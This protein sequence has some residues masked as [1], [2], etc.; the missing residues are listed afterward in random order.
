M[1]SFTIA[2]LVGAAGVIVGFILMMAF[3]KKRTKP[4]APSA[5]VKP[6]GK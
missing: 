1:D 3:D 4:Q 5:P 2:V 6:T